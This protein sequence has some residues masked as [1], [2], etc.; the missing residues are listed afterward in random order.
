[1]TN[2][3]RGASSAST[4]VGVRPTFVDMP[5]MRPDDEDF[6]LAM[7][8]SLHKV[9]NL[10][11]HPTE[12]VA[13]LCGEGISVEKVSQSATKLGYNPVTFPPSAPT[14][15][16]RNH[17]KTWLRGTGGLLVTSNL[18]FS[19]MEAPTCVFITNKL[20]EETG[21]RSG[22]LRATS[23]LV[24]VSYTKDIN[25]EEVKMRFLVKWM[26]EELRK[27]EERRKE[28][29]MKKEEER[30][31]EEERIRKGWEPLAAEVDTA[32]KNGDIERVKQLQQMETSGI[33]FII[34][35]IEI[36]LIAMIFVIII[37]ITIQR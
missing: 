13:I 26:K 4:V 28:E 17:L 9:L 6:T 25:R 11:P 37:I 35:H 12:H 8:E 34:G 5:E 22:L 32:A 19:G 33:D 16:E 29:E 21:A 30:R 27:K 20:D 1:M 18:Q 15:D 24:V 10:K 2:V 23:R 7:E 36:N 31:K 3:I 14:E